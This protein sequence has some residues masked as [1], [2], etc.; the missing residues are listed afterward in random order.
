MRIDLTTPSMQPMERSQESRDTTQ[1]GQ[2][3]TGAIAGNN[4]DTAELSTSSDA[5]A[6]LRAQLDSVPDVRQQRV[7]SLRQVIQSGQFAV[8]PQRI[9][10]AMLA[11]G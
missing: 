8:S 6:A 9:A 10:D 1:A 5:V 2:S 7:D 11:T 4:N 3:Q